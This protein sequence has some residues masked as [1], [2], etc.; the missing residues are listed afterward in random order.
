MKRMIS[1]LFAA[2]M[3][4]GLAFWTAG[5]EEAD[6]YVATGGQ[7]IDQQ[8]Y[9]G[10]WQQA[11]MQILNSHSER[12]HAY[13]NRTLE[14]WMNDEAMV[15][16]CKPVSLTDITGDGTPELIFMEAATD[17]RGDLYIYGASGGNI[18]C[19]LYIPGITRLGYDDVGLGFD[20]Y[21]SSADDGTLVAEYEE[22]EWPWVLQLKQN[23]LGQYTLLNYLRAEYDNS[24]WDNDRY[25]RNG[26]R[27]SGDSYEETLRKLRDGR[28]MTISSYI[29]EGNTHYGFSM[30]W[31][32]AASL[33][34][35]WNYE[36]TAVP[37]SG[38]NDDRLFGLT[39]DKLATR[40]GPGTQYE[41]GGT[42]S[43]K[44]E[45]IE[46]L[47]KAYDKRNGIWWVKC[48][49]PYHG[50]ERILWTGYKRFD[51]DTLPLD[52]IPEEVW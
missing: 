4:C 24:D 47:A 21:L 17:D 8:T 1:F 19:I 2:V 41:G 23:A 35:G 43:V 7:I 40:K 14:Y 16:P 27:I 48:V 10:S 45:Y 50:E 51:K 29:A 32:S 20:I 9:S 28:T 31:E 42:Y 3:L 18:K 46:V 44:G 33:I 26:T 39:I 49:I 25:Y 13:Q 6:G 36:P 37:P 34:S 52:L 5:A 15:V 11:Y 22:Y 30:D 12:I 38:Q